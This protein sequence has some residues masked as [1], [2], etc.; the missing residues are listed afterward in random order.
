MSVIINVNNLPTVFCH[1]PQ[2]RYNQNL[3]YTKSHIL[4]MALSYSTLTPQSTDT[5]Q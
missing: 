3:L 5:V 4:G 2:R 1:W